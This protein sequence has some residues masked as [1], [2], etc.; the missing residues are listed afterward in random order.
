MPTRGEPNSVEITGIMDAPGSRE[1]TINQ[2]SQDYSQD[3]P[4]TE[5]G[6][7]TFNIRVQEIKDMEDEGIGEPWVDFR[8]TKLTISESQ[9]DI[10]FTY[11]FDNNTEYMSASY[12]LEGA[13]DASEMAVTIIDPGLDKKGEKQVSKEAGVL[14]QNVTVYTL[15]ANDLSGIWTSIFHGADNYGDDY[16]NHTN[17]RLTPVN[18]RNSKKKL[19]VIIDPGHGQFFNA[20]DKE[21][22]GSLK[23][24]WRGGALDLEVSDDYH[25]E[26]AVLTVS[27]KTNAMLLQWQSIIA[28][29]EMTRT[30]FFDV[31]QNADN[32]AIGCFNHGLIEAGKETCP[33]GE[34]TFDKR[35]KIAKDFAASN[36]ANGHNV[37]F[38]SIHTTPHGYGLLNR[39]PRTFYIYADSSKMET[40]MV[41]KSRDLGDKIIQRLENIISYYHP[42]ID[43]PENQNL[44]ILLQAGRNLTQVT[45]SDFGTTSYHDPVNNKDYVITSQQKATM[46]K[47][48]GSAVYPAVLIESYSHGKSAWAQEL[49]N[50]ANQALLGRAIAQGILDYGINH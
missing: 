20:Q 45:S 38:V 23:R 41:S 18:K 2:L 33:V 50:G 8:S 36:Q 1:V 29:T 7:Y 22:D 4:L 49:K 5:W 28:A 30:G 10:E 24:Q 11:D 40:G 6:V 9:H 14:H 47:S 19:S 16:R 32:S 46:F 48:Y 35:V 42:S 37:V 26:D 17:K 34:R 15:T 13:K 12:L 43:S 25:E 3:H 39:Y 31:D 27:F 21:E 44:Q